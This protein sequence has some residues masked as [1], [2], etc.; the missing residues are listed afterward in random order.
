MIITYVL[1]LANEDESLYQDKKNNINQ[2]ILDEYQGYTLVSTS[3]EESGEY[4]YVTIH[5]E[6]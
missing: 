1:C 4:K 5:L 2:S 3:I 6:E